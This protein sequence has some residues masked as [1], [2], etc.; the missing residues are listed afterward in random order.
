MKKYII[1]NGSMGTGKTDVGRRV[2][3][4][5]YGTAF[6]DGDFVI[7]IHPFEC[8]DYTSTKF[9]RL[10]NILHLSKNYCNFDDCKNIVLSWIM[11]EDLASDLIAEIS[12]LNV[13]LHH[14]VLTCN[15]EAL[16]ERWKNDKVN[17]WRD[18][19]NLQMAI[20]QLEYFSNL[21]DAIVVDTSKLSVDMVANEI[22]KIV[23]A[24]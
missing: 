13:C 15:A 16:T 9:M 3:E 19:G 7:E 11:Y 21:P 12:K 8:A 20:E 14:F 6:I 17:D 18:D 23:G 24:K 22:I 5:L 1:I 10:D 4:K 2:A